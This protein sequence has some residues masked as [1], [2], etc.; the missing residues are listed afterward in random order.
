ML[1]HE[2]SVLRLL[3]LLSTLCL[4]EDPVRHEATNVLLP[5]RLVHWQ[6]NSL[7]SH[8]I[9]LRDDSFVDVL[10]NHYASN[11]V[12]Q[13]LLSLQKKD[14]TLKSESAHTTSKGLEARGEWQLY[15]D[16]QPCAS[17]R[18]SRIRNVSRSRLHLH[19][20]KQHTICSY[21]HAICG[22]EVHSSSSDE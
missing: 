3:S 14:A 9:I 7:S 4:P 17:W 19:P 22:A 16:Y 8:V 2:K 11:D 21:K 1:Q 5:M 12:A 18:A 10:L 15:P 13:D 20:C 6:R